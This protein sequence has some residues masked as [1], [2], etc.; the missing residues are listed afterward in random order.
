MMNARR[1]QILQVRYAYPTVLLRQR[2]QMLVYMLA[3]IGVVWV[4]VLLVSAFP[5][6]SVTNTLPTPVW[7]VILAA[8]VMIFVAYRAIQNGRVNTGASIFTAYLTI[9]TLVPAVVLTDQHIGFILLLPIIAA[10]VLL[11]RSNF[12]LVLAVCLV[13]LFVRLIVLSQ[14]DG[15]IRYAPSL[16]SAI[17]VG[18]AG[19]LMLAVGVFLISFT[20]TAERL[21]NV[22]SESTRFWQAFSMFRAGGDTDIDILA[23][24]A[25]RILRDQLGYSLAQLYIVD[26]AGNITRRLRPDGVIDRQIMRRVDELPALGD[27]VRDRGV[28]FFRRDASALQ[29]YPV[30]PA[31]IG[32]AVPIIYQG[33]VLGVLD[34]QT[35]RADDPTSEQ[36][37]AFQAFADSLAA[38]FMNARR[39]SELQKTVDDQEGVIAS[40]RT[41]LTELQSSSAQLVGGGW[42]RYL[43]GRGGQAIGF[44]VEM[45]DGAPV[46][47]PAADLPPFIRETLQRGD[48]FT[49][50]APDHVRVHVPIV[51]RDDVLGAMTFT[52]PPGR[53]L[54]ERQLEAVRVV[55]QRLAQSLENNRLFE[56]SQAQAARERKAS[57]VSALLI[58]ATTV[59]SLLELAANSFNEALGAVYTR[60]VLEPSADAETETLNGSGGYVNGSG[61]TLDPENSEWSD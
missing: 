23:E 20:G 39:L 54:T 42:S 12:L 18:I 28:R 6:T 57:E 34:A 61:H 49:E 8:P 46:T 55:S 21:T 19:G 56:L 22:A 36:L 11:N 5:A 43:E 40:F 38:A 51:L 29:E 50:T 52:L 35:R 10:G 15:I 17:E 31:R 37:V 59:E 3:T 25:L 14:T 60:V 58:S 26:E 33:I 1:E 9:G 27:A 32:I 4:A 13:G 41:R 53:G 48:T 2:A 24:Q 45:S 47:T 7:L 44:D 30:A 16:D